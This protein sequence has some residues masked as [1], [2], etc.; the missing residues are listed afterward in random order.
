MHSYDQTYQA[1]NDY[2]GDVSPLLA[3]HK[4]EIKPGGRVLDIGVGQG[5][6]ALALAA[7]GFR[8]TGIDTSAEAIEQCRS[9]AAA[10]GLD[11]ELHHV[12]VFDHHDAEPYDAVLCFGLMQILSRGDNA[13]LVHRIFEWTS[14]ASVF[15]L[16]AW[17]V[18]DPSYDRIRDTWEKV[19]LHCFVSPEGEYRTY[20]GRN[21]IKDIFRKWNAVHY[22]EGLGP[23]HRHGEGEEH[24]HGNIEMVAVR[25]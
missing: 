10:K 16:T 3:T 15:F 21:V 24:Q 11:I 19:A 25:R 9:A 14:P 6:N 17:H 22:E 20:M 2:F 8:V 1:T 7:Q 13:S 5:R 4:G 18:D 23:L 12:D